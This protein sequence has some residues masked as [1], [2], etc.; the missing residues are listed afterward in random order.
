MSEPTGRVHGVASIKAEYVVARTT[1]VEELDDDVAER[2]TNPATTTE[3]ECGHADGEEP[4]VKRVKLSGAAK[5]RAK[6]E[7]EAEKKRSNRGQNKA[8]RFASIRDQNLLC[9][10][11]ARGRQCVRDK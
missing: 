9:D 7:A 8:R 3:G 10:R 6:R 1:S 2:A 4:S 5:K 11:V